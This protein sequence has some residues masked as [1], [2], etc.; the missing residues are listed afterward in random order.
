[1]GLLRK[2][3]RAIWVY[4]PKLVK[5]KEG[6][7]TLSYISAPQMY[8]A[9]VQPVSDVKV[10]A[11]Y[12]ALERELLRAVIERTLDGAEVKINDGVSLEYEDAPPFFEVVSVLRPHG[13]TILTLKG[14]LPGAP[15]TRGQASAGRQA[16]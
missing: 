6:V 7:V 3:Q 12:G 1:M 2:W 15:A 9:H 5:D 16:P 8:T 14:A 13:C 10:L 11:E 4:R